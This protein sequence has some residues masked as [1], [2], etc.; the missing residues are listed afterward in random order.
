MDANLDG[1]VLWKADLKDSI[2]TNVS[3]V[4]ATL[5]H[6]NLSG[7]AMGPIDLSEASLQ[8]VTAD[9]LFPYNGLVKIDNVDADEAFKTR[10]ERLNG[11]GSRVAPEDPEVRVELVEPEE[12][13]GV[14]LGTR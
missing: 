3:M 8:G 4:G 11:P 7:V 9:T 13:L 1:A 6:A 10:L 2:L 12:D 5:L 14:G